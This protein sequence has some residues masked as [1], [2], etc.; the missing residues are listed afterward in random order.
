VKTF[1]EPSSDRRKSFEEYVASRPRLVDYAQFRATG[2]RFKKPWHEWPDEMR[3]G[4]TSELAFDEDARRY[5]MYVQWLAEEQ[6]RAAAGEGDRKGLYLDL[7]L[8]VN[9]NGYDV[10]RERSLFAVGVAGGSPPDVVFP[11]GQNWGFVPLHPENIRKQGYQYIRDFLHHQMRYAKV[12]RIDHMPSFH[13]VF[14]IP[15]GAEARDG[16]YVRYPAD[17]L[18]AV[19]NLESHRHRTVLV[20][21]DLGT[22]PPEVPRA[23]AR[24]N[25]HR[26][27]VVQYE[28]K[29]NPHAAL[30][31]PPAS[32]IASVNTHDMSPFAGFW[33]G[34]DFLEFEKAGILPAEKLEEQTKTREALKTAIQQFL[35]G[36]GYADEPK[37]D[38]DEIYKACL[39][40]LRDSPARMILVNLEDLWGEVESQNVPSTSGESHNWRRKA[41]YTFEQMT[42]DPRVNELLAQLSPVS[43]SRK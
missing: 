33:E 39:A 16:V 23:M 20:G 36:A 8:G 15:P 25:V 2:E 42:A 19:F 32:S 1:F 28:L 38:A 40:F 17:E 12:L 5:H 13:R 41:R 6:L 7:P 18:Y 3:N 30:P 27:Y 24:H 21:E 35:H 29:P 43:C 11:K 9:A 4:T 34:H 37:S 14:W 26:M 22:V 31:E 10:W